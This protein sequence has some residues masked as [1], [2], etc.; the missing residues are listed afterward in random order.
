MAMIVKI[1]VKTNNIQLEVY[2]VLLVT[3]KCVPNQMHVYKGDTLSQRSTINFTKKHL[4]FVKQFGS[5]S[6]RPEPR[7]LNWV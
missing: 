6:G 1:N 2:H 5:R 7:G 3:G 4:N